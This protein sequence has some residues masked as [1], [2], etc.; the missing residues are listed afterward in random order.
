MFSLCIFCRISSVK[1]YIAVNLRFSKFPKKIHEIKGWNK[2]VRFKFG[3][4]ECCC[5]KRKGGCVNLE[6]G[7]IQ[8]YSR[9]MQ[10]FWPPLSNSFEK[11]C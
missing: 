9:R 7:Q 5:V 11:R 1:K 6:L 8:I 10:T 2:H 4:I 3:E